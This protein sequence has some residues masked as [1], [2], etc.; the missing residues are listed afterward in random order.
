MAEAEA[1]AH[2][3]RE[4]ITARLADYIAAELGWTEP[5]DRDNAAEN[6]TLA[7]D[8]LVD[9]ADLFP[10]DRW[11]EDCHQCTR[12]IGDHTVDG[13]CPPEVTGYVVLTTQADGT[14]A[15]DWEDGEV[16]VDQAAAGAMLVAARCSV[17]QHAAVLGV[18]F[19]VADG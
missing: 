8:G 14:L 7:V 3:S 6:A 9:S 13:R 2:C 16:H 4:Q 17:G 11:D 15:A 5:E 10:S 19:Q 1:G 12:R 18:V